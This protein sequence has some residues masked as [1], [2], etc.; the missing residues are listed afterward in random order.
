MKGVGEGGGCRKD[1]G[2]GGG[3]GEGKGGAIKF[4]SRQQTTGTSLWY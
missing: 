1:C 2:W 3:G 4:G